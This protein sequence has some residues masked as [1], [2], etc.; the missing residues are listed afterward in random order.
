MRYVPLALA[1]LCA[2][3]AGEAGPLPTAEV[4]I[5]GDY[6]ARFDAHAS[7][8]MGPREGLA[9]AAAVFPPVLLTATDFE[10]S[11]TAAS[12]ETRIYLARQREQRP[13]VGEYEIGDLVGSFL[14]PADVFYAGIRELEVEGERFGLSGT[15][16]TLAV[17][18]SEPGVVEGSFEFSA[19][20]AAR[21]EQGN[22]I[23][24][25]V[26][27]RVEGSFRSTGEDA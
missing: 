24:E 17:T 2:C 11:L 27:V 10:L 26:R 5:A 3:D 13:Q 20:G 23:G 19:V 9:F 12:G 1:L 18:R 6:T 4:S 21:D 25:T 8:E 15:E 22:Q 7:Y 14:D 16:G